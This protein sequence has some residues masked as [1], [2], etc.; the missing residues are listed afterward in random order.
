[1]N[2]PPAELTSDRAFARRVFLDAIGQLPGRQELAEFL[3]DSQQDKRSNLIDRLLAR[4]EYASHWRVKF[5]DWF[6]NSQLNSQGRSM[7][8]FKDWIKRWLSQDRP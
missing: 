3:D 5:E 6:R 2:V 1:M 7:G 8:V 4:P